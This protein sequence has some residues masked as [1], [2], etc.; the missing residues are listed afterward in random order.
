M[1]SEVSCFYS[2]TGLNVHVEMAR[3]LKIVG[4]GQ[5]VT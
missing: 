3:I 4:Q 1:G 2:T 5:T